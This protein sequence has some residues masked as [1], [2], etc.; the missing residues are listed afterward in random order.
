D[1]GQRSRL[2]ERDGHPDQSLPVALSEPGLGA[3]QECISSSVEGPDVEAIET[4]YVACGIKNARE[5]LS[6]GQWFLESCRKTVELLLVAGE[7]F[8]PWVFPGEPP[9]EPRIVDGQSRLGG[10][11]REQLNRLRR[12]LPRRF[13]IHC[14]GADQVILADQGHRHD[15]AIPSLD[16][17]SADR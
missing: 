5:L 3:D 17:R 10:E 16:E 6:Q 2:V 9:K 4:D 15:C 1:G 8:K 14:Q 12:E 11:C 7:S 13:A